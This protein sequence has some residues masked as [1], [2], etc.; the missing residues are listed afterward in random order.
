MNFSDFCGQLI[1][2]LGGLVFFAGDS[3]LHFLVYPILKQF[4]F[5]TE[6]VDI[7]LAILRVKDLR[8]FRSGRVDVCRDLQVAR[9]G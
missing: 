9:L 2:L 7:N 3:L 6:Q 5:L 1:E 4:N 8:E